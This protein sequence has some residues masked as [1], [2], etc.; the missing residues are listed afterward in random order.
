M[1]NLSGELFAL[2]EQAR[3]YQTVL[4]VIVTTTIVAIWGP[5]TLTRRP[6]RKA[7]VAA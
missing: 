5:Q 3:F 1:V 7:A 2:T 4:I 6:Q